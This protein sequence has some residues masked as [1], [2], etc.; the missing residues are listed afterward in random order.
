MRRID[1]RAQLENYIA[2]FPEATTL[3][4]QRYVP[5]AGEAAVLYARQPGEASG[6]ILSLTFRYFPHVVGN[7]R[8]TVRQLIRSDERAQWKSALHLGVDPTHRGVGPVDLDR[9]PARG[10]VV[11]MR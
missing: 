4:L 11:R 3:M 7:D 8:M 9:I 1:E 5:H 6:R 2:H 10:E